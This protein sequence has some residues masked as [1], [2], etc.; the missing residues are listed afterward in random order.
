[1][2]AKSSGSG[3]VTRPDAC[4]LNSGWVQ[5]PWSHTWHS[6]T[7]ARGQWEPGCGQTEVQVRHGLLSAQKAEKWSLSYRGS[8]PCPAGP[9]SQACWTRP[10][11]C[12]MGSSHYT[13]GPEEDP[14]LH[15]HNFRRLTQ[16]LRSLRVDSSDI[17]LSCSCASCLPGYSA[18]FLLFISKPLIALRY[19]L[20]FYLLN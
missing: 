5:P 2:A 14:R 7:G 18:F 12:T 20:L 1:M 8:K 11:L 4:A 13:R 6:A 9:F 19:W 16:G 10:P 3:E 15:G 17:T